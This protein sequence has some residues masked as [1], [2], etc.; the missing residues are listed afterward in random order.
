[1]GIGTLNLRN[2]QN[3]GRITTSAARTH[4]QAA[5]LRPSRRTRRE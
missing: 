5:D 3:T 1:M 2:A 4:G